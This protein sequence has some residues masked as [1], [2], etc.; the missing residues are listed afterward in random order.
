MCFLNSLVLSLYHVVAFRCHLA[1]S[2]LVAQGAGL[3]RAGALAQGA[4]RGTPEAQRCSR[5]L[6]RHPRARGRWRRTRCAT[7]LR[8]CP[9]QRRS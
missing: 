3:H 8:Q 9:A 4:L 5:R 7:R 1:A 6:R 2:E